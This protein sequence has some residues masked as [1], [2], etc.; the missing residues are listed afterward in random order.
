[1]QCQVPVLAVPQITEKTV[2]GIHLVHGE[3]IQERNVEEIMEVSVPHVMAKISSQ[4]RVQ[5]RTVEQ[6]V[7]VPRS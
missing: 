3:R 7:D 6:T 5:D 2:E 1:M 4:K